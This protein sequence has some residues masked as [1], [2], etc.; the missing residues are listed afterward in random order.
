M[1]QP[2]TSGFGTIRARR[3]GRFNVGVYQE[4]GVKTKMKHINNC[5][6]VFSVQFRIPTR[7]FVQLVYSRV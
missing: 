3:V 5:A 2:G 6:H 4:W 1:E 7:R